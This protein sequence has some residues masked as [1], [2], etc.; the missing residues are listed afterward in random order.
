MGPDVLVLEPADDDA[1]VDPQVGGELFDF[2]ES[3]DC[4]QDAGPF[5]R[6]QE[7]RGELIGLALLVG[8][9][10]GIAVLLL[11]VDGALRSVEDVLGL[12]EER[13]PEDVAP[14][15]PEAQLNQRPAAPE[16]VGYTGGAL[17]SPRRVD[18][19]GTLPRTI[20]LMW[21]V[22]SPV[23]RANS[24]WLIDS[25]SSVSSSVQPGGVA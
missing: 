11:D 20:R 25:S 21:F 18:G 14:P 15:E 10:L 2:V 19:V 7:I 24:A 5:L 8:S 22:G 1:R 13:E 9:V 12:V 4:P 16:P 6:D 3:A 17:E 23:R